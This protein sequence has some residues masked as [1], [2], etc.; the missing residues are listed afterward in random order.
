[1]INDISQLIK[2]ISRVIKKLLR[3]F[4]G[5]A[6]LTFFVLPLAGVFPVILFLDL[7]DSEISLAAAG[8]SL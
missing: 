5:T 3:Y 1:M 6:I 2:G 7:N 8:S 4:N